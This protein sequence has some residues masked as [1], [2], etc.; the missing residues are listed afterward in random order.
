MALKRK[1]SRRLKGAGMQIRSRFKRAKASASKFNFTSARAAALKKAQEASAKARRL[2]SNKSARTLAVKGAKMKIRSKFK[3]S[4]AGAAVR[5]AKTS[6]NQAGGNTKL[7]RAKM[8]V[9]NT[10]K[11]ASATT[12][13]GIA[14]AKSRGGKAANKAQSTIRSK[15]RGVNKAS[16]TAKARGLQYQAL[17]MA[18]QTKKKVVKKAVAIKDK[19]KATKIGQTSRGYSPKNTTR[20]RSGGK[21]ATSTPVRFT[22]VLKAS[23]LGQTGRRSSPSNVSSSARR[24]GTNAT[25]AFANARRYNVG[26]AQNNPTSQLQV[27]GAT[28][29]RAQTASMQRSLVSAGMTTLGGTKQ[30]A[31][32]NNAYRSPILEN[33]RQ[34]LMYGGKFQSRI[35]E[36]ARK[37]YIGYK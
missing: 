33:V 32:K 31:S 25:N 16:I 12:K 17:G 14:I 20:S 29:N 7:L 3:Q 1:V 36:R 26:K 10:A 18:Q 6:F 5:S 35:L 28:K 2:A 15:T 9:T 30:G 13:S 4:K 34:N 19:R 22:P 8:R 21:A 11:R 24:T 23:R 37:A 27:M